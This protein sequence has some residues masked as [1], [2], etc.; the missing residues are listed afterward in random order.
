MGS[1]HFFQRE[2]HFFSNT[3]MSTRLGGTSPAAARLGPY[4]GT[5]PLVYG[6]R[7]RV[8]NYEVEYKS[9]QSLAL[10]GRELYRARAYAGRHLNDMSF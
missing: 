8:S 10:G 3:T 1:S 5:E 4:G 7:E 9:L 6:G 2:P